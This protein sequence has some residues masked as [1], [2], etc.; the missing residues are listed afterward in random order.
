MHIITCMLFACLLAYNVLCPIYAKKYQNLPEFR[1]VIWV[2][3]WAIFWEI[4]EY[5][6][7]RFTHVVDINYVAK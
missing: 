3:M 1:S 5:N 2:Y 4:A 7:L 6:W